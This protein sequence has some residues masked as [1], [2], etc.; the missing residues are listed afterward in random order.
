[1]RC[2]CCFSELPEDAAKCGVCGYPCLVIVE[3]GDDA[4]REQM[5]IDFLRMK[6]A[7]VSLYITAHRYR[8]H[9]EEAVPDG[10]EALRLCDALSLR[11][12]ETVW[13]D[14]QFAALPSGRSFAAELIVRRGQEERRFPLTVTPQET[15][16]HARIGAYL[17][18]G[19]QVRLAFGNAEKPVLSDAAPLLS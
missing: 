8:L 15:I 16:S 6:L 17:D 18:D 14:A 5:R 12:G 4:A 11:H 1:M 2:E 9:E 3:E 19:L 7:G 13:A 10:T